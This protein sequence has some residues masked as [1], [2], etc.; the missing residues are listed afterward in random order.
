MTAPSLQQHPD[1]HGNHVS[2]RYRI[3]LRRSPIRLIAITRSLTRANSLRLDVN[4]LKRIGVKEMRY[5]H[6]QNVVDGDDSVNSGVDSHFRTRPQKEHQENIEVEICYP[7][8][9]RNPN[10]AEFEEVDHGRLTLV[11]I[12]KYFF[13]VHKNHANR[14]LT[15]TSNWDNTMNFR[16]PFM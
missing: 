15:A 3:R 2:D 11:P 8:C 5:R 1:D 16:L 7:R 12:A 6:C 10:S 14:Y 9:R 4:F 13:G